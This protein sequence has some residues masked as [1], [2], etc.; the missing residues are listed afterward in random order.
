MAKITIQLPNGISPEI[1]I[2]SGER[3]DFQIVSKIIEAIKKSGFDPLAGGYSIEDFIRNDI[4]ASIQFT[5]TKEEKENIIE[6]YKTKFNL[7][8]FQ[9]RIQDLIEEYKKLLGS[10][11]V[12]KVLDSEIEELQPQSP[13]NRIQRKSQERPTEFP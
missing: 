4:K 5:L 10:E 1:S 13:F 3:S 9:D 11:L 2:V 6:V 8:E 7:D 12:I